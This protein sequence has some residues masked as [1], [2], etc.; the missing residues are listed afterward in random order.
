MKRSETNIIYKRSHFSEDLHSKSTL[1]QQ[2]FFL[3][4]LLIQFFY[5]KK[6]TI[7]L[8]GP[9]RKINYLLFYFNIYLIYNNYFYNILFIQ[10]LILQFF[11]IFPISKFLNYTY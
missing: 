8:I 10:L 3:M 7:F 9:H 5:I 6:T 1:P 2:I 4:Y 11:S